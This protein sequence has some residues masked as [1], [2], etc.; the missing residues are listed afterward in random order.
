MGNLPTSVG[1]RGPEQIAV[2]HGMVQRKSQAQTHVRAHVARRDGG[3]AHTS[4]PNRM[5]R[6]SLPDSVRVRLER[7]RLP[8]VLRNE[9]RHAPQDAV[10]FKGFHGRVC[11]PRRSMPGQQQTRQ[12][13][14]HESTACTTAFLAGLR[15]EGWRHTCTCTWIGKNAPS[16]PF[17]HDSCWPT[18]A[19]QQAISRIT[20]ATWAAAEW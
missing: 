6:P 17:L 14:T 5:E 1:V 3:R 13:W 12:E 10:L 16:Q 18:Q 2:V 8:V 19:Q 11:E 9:L 7:K 4:G 20:A 15:R